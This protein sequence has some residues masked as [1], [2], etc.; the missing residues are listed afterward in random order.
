MDSEVREK[1]EVGGVKEAK[2]RECIKK[3]SMVTHV[4]S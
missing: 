2:R 3:K 1:P 4:E